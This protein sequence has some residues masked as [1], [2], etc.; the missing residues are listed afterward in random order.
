MS[1]LWATSW[2]G[3]TDQ[4]E[5]LFKLPPLLSA[6]ST[7]MDH[8]AKK[9]AAL[10]VVNS[11]KYLIWTDDEAIPTKGLTYDTIKD[12]SLLIRPKPNRGLRPEHLDLIERYVLES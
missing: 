5:K 4:L 11:G 10:E 3:H 9:R 7:A 12:R 6:G 8:Q 1:I 2:V